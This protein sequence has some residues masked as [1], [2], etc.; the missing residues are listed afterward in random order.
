MPCPRTGGLG[1]GQGPQNA[2]KKFAG[3]REGAAER[4]VWGGIPPRP[5]EIFSKSQCRDFPEKRFEFYPKETVVN[6]FYRETELRR[7]QKIANKV[8]FC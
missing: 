2:Y 5:S 1:Q 8:L 6:I 7:K 4:E 3:P